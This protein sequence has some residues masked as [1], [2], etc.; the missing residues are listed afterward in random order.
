MKLLTSR[1]PYLHIS[2]LLRSPVPSDTTHHCQVT[3]TTKAT[4]GL[5]TNLGIL[6]SIHLNRENNVMFHLVI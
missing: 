4:V 6:H 1:L 5:F 3:E 2:S